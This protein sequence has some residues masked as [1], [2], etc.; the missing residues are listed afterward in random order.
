MKRLLL[1]LGLLPMTCLGAGLVNGTISGN[2]NGGGSTTATATNISVTG[3]VVGGPGSTV[4]TTFGSTGTNVI[5]SLSTTAAGNV[6]NAGGFV[7]TGTNVL[8]IDNSTTNSLAYSATNPY[9]LAWKTAWDCTST[10]PLTTIGAI[11]VAK[12]GDWIYFAP[13]ATP[14]F[15]PDLPLNLW[16]PNSNGLN[17]LTP[18]N[19]MVIQT[20][21]AAGTNASPIATGQNQGS[22]IFPGNN[23][24]IVIDGQVVCTNSTLN[25]P[26][27]EVIGWQLSSTSVGPNAAL[28]GLTNYPATP[29]TIMGR[30]Q[31]F[32]LSDGAQI[33]CGTNYSPVFISFDGPSFTSLYDALS[34]Q[35]VV[36]SNNITATFGPNCFFE[37]TNAPYAGNPSRGISLINCNFAIQGG[38]YLAVGVTGGVNDNGAGDNAA[39]SLGACNGSI[40][41]SKLIAIGTTNVVPLYT[42]QG[43]FNLGVSAP[44][45]NGSEG[46]YVTGSWYEQGGYQGYS[47]STF[48][49]T[50]FITQTPTNMVNTNQVVVY[51]SGAFGANGVNGLYIGDADG[52][53]TMTNARSATEYL[54]NS[55]SGTGPFQLISGGTLKGYSAT[56]TGTYVPTNS[57]TGTPVAI[58][59]NWIGST[60]SVIYS[61]N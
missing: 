27:T 23:S 51:N 47:N 15:V 16:G 12:P 29:V 46:S 26:Y 24:T 54:T 1:V 60:R 30:G 9:R 58:Y 49:T 14:Y 52:L 3:V 44:Y 22:F 56:V 7:P 43:V 50:G 34:L 35:G 20:N 10:N 45:I 57:V 55:V 13:S 2:G 25:G 28:V 53:G 5:N 48:V 41:G 39:I 61:A 37:V 4:S 6:V 59:T 18:I 33:T 21:Y 8:V 38:R 17:L 19:A 31:V 40:Q 42:G 36:G 32:A 11:T